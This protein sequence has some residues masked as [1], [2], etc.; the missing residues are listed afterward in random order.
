VVVHGERELFPSATEGEAA[1]ALR[2]FLTAYNKAQK[3]NDRSL[4]AGRVSGALADID[5]AKLKAGHKTSPDGNS[6]YKA[7]ELTDTKYTIPKKAGWPRWFVADSASNRDGNRW[8]LVFTRTGPDA[9]WQVSYLTV[10]AAAD[11]PVFKKDADGWAEPVSAGD[12]GLAVA[13]RKLGSAYA[14]YLEK[15]G[16]AFA[17]GVFTDRLR[18]TRKKNAS[19][20]GLARQYVDEGLSGGAYTPLGLRTKDGSALVFFATH[21]YEKQTAAQGVDITVTDP[22]IKA[23]M[24][25][26]DPKQSL[27]LVYVSN[28][29]VLDPV[30]TADGGKVQFL[31][32]VAGLTGAKG[33]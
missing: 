24:T 6:S 27:T 20:P 4:D 31:S 23:L 5:G 26:G 1:K 17:P 28:Q 25:G 21:H 33:E 9:V 7:L 11:V 16:T 32:R 2:G 10:L 14:T 12:T 15:G 8:L 13:P 30:K 19:R 18:A 3:A 22:N 29:A